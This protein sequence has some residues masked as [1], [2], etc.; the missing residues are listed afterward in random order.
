M[1]EDF[2][3]KARELLKARCVGGEKTPGVA[4]VSKRGTRKVLW[5]W[6][7]Q[8]WTKIGTN[9]LGPI[10]GDLPESKLLPIIDAI[11][12]VEPQLGDDPFLGHG[13]ITVTDMHVQTPSINAVPDEALI[14]I[15]RRVTFGEDP[16]VEL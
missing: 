9:E 15:D 5:R 7:E 4:L 2:A 14:Y 12:K 16:Q 13:R 6:I 3:K 1:V 10:I 11:S 8:N